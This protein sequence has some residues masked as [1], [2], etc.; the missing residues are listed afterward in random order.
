MTIH[1]RT[2]HI[3]H[4]KLVR[5]RDRRDFW[6]VSIVLLIV[7]IAV[8]A[9]SGCNPQRVGCQQSHNFVGVH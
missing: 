5:K 6:V 9:F 3:E 4:R 8:M 1:E 7:T 2:A